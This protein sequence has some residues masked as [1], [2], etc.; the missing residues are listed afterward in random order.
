MAEIM[1]A[2]GAAR[3]SPVSAVVGALSTTVAC[4]IPVFLVGGLAVQMGAELGF[5][6]AGLG[7]AVAV[8]FGVSALASVPAGGLVERFGA[9]VIARLAICLSAGCLLAIAG[10]ARSLVLLIV[11]LGAGAAANALGQLASN[12]ALAH[13]VPRA[14]Q[15]LSFG[16][17]QAAVPLSTLLAGLAVPAVALTWGWRWAFVLAAGVALAALPLV[18]REHRQRRHAA[19]T[20]D[21]DRATAALVVIGLAATLAAAAANAL[22]TFLVDATVARGLEPGLAGLT[23]T[24]GS[25]VCVAARIGGGALADRWTDGHLAAIAGLLAV[26]AVGV[27]LLAVAGPVALVVGVLLGF[28]LGWAWPGLQ[29]YAVV[30]LHPQAPAAA[31]SIT[32][33]G[34]YAGACIGP[35]ALGAVAAH[36]GYPTMWVVAAVTM[37][38]AAVFMLLGGRMLRAAAAARAADAGH[39]ARSSA[40]EAAATPAPPPAP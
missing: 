25:V 22:G 11:L 4:V 3:G 39:A 14:R 26:G 20:G 15:G 2:E 13:R 34:I 29:N 30:R 12:A 37:L 17:K 21:G 10:F 1:S 18:P 33:T 8:Y 24:L 23:L 38:G 16:L 28:G 31:T 6:P 5:S 19:G 35:L 40:P 32:Q 9:V 7:L 27:S 36:A